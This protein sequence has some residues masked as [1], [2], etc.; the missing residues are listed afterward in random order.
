MS[1]LTELA[2]AFDMRE[3]QGFTIWRTN[4]GHLQVNIQSRDGGWD[5]RDF[6][7]LADAVSHIERF[8]ILEEKRG[9]RKTRVAKD[10][11]ELKRKAEAL[12][13]RRRADDLA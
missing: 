11:E 6:A 13:A 9:V 10:R 8:N 12:R 4:D 7:E 3:C 2:E 1:F 5:C